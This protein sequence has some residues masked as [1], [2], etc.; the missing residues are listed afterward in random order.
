MTEIKET[1]SNCKNS[2]ESGYKISLLANALIAFPYI[3][4]VRAAD[5]FELHNLNTIPSEAFTKNRPHPV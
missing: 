5:L 2:V 3:C 4:S 1:V